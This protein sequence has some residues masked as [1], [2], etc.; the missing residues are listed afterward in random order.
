MAYIYKITNMLNGKSYIGKTN[1]SVN[2]RF[3]QHKSDCHRRQMQ[4][5]PLYDAMNKYG[6]QNF[7]VD[8]VE[9][10]SPEE[11]SQRQI[12]WIDFFDTYKNG[13]NATSGGDGKQLF[14]Y[15]EISEKYKQIQSQ[16]LT[17]EYFGC[18]IDT[19]R[20]ACKEYNINTN[21]QR[22]KRP[23]YIIFNNGEK[24]IFESIY[25]AAKYIAPE[26]PVRSV[27]NSITHALKNNRTIYG[28]DVGYL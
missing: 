23:I 10:V 21:V 17:A 18:G 26:K 19:V 14:D 1:L 15:K 20:V 22:N 5:R 7:I 12:Y 24:M 13:Y 16:K 3:N 9:Q 6:Y 8:V 11:S 4:K 27:K 28:Y 25:E 2:D